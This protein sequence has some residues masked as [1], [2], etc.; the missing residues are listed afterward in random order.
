MA[1]KLILPIN[2][3][4]HLREIEVSDAPAIFHIINTQREYLGKW[5]P[6]VAATESWEDTYAFIQ[7]VKDQKVPVVQIVFS[8]YRDK[9]LV[10]LISVLNIDQGNRKAEIGYWISQNEQHQGI[11]TKSVLA[12]I[13]YCFT[14]LML[15]RVQIRCGTEN[16]SSRKIPER[17]GFTLEGVE[18]DSELMSDG[19]FV[20]H[21]VYSLLWIE[22]M[23]CKYRLLN[24][25]GLYKTL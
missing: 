19:H 11:V 2:N 1:S 23:E 16:L 15:N 9:N 20:D 24:S 21:A 7:S 10:G 8:I 6:F 3:E 18:R 13:N 14:D 4:L 12:V 5:L 17:L 25:P 22:W